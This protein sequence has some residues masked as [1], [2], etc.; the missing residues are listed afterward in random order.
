MRTL[1]NLLIALQVFGSGTLVK[2]QGMSRAGLTPVQNKLLPFQSD[3][4]TAWIDGF[5]G[6][7]YTPCCLQHDYKY[8]AGGTQKEKLAADIELMK[9]VTKVQGPIQGPI[10]GALMFAGVRMAGKLHPTNVYRWGFGWQY[11][12]DENAALSTTEK[13]M[14][15]Q[16][17]P[18]D[19]NKVVLKHMTPEELAQIK[20]ESYQAEP[21]PTVTGNYCLDEVAAKL[22]QSNQS[23]QNLE[24]RPYIN[25]S[26]PNTYTIKTNLCKNEIL[27]TF[28][29]PSLQ[30][31]TDLHYSTQPTHYLKLMHGFGDCRDKIYE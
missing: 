21:Y 19:L 4:C 10:I 24:L 17:T 1:L 27:V 16:L 9:C 12:R 25:D 29:I 6:K 31:C 30:M 22:I 13:S 11:Y 15:A 14:V 8:W 2:A 18:P 7:D 26:L 23:I 28:N 5:A 3:S 20:V